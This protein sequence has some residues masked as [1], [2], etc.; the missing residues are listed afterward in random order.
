MGLKLVCVCVTSYDG[1][2]TLE[3]PNVLS[4]DSL[5]AHAKRR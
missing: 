3:L 4:V 2:E 5:Q 1:G